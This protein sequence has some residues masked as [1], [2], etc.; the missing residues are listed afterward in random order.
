MPL[1][2][3]DP[4]WRVCAEGAQML[5][6]HMTRR[7]LQLEEGVF[8]RLLGG[9]T[10]ALGE[11]LSAQRDGHCAGLDTCLSPAAAQEA[12][13]GGVVVVATIACGDERATLCAPAYL[14]GDGRLVW[15]CDEASRVR[16]HDMLRG[17]PRA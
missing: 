4:A 14:H 3:R 13:S 12:V 1:F 9:E 8:R 7:R 5:A 17:E 16:F 6:R 15:G 10:I 11:L 2:A